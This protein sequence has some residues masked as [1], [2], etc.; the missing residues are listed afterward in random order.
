MAYQYR[1]ALLTEDEYRA[2][3]SIIENG[4]GDGDFAGYAGRDPLVQEAAMKKFSEAQRQPIAK[5]AP[6]RKYV[7]KPKSAAEVALKFAK[8]GR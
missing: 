8:G 6:K 4:W 3:S 1:V 7:K 5:P 2:L